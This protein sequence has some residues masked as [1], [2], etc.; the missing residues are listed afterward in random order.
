MSPAADE[1]LQAVRH[2]VER[3]NA[4]GRP[5][6]DQNIAAELGM[7]TAQLHATMRQLFSEGRRVEAEPSG[8]PDGDEQ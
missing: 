8:Q 3:L 2:A 4:A 7:T 1:T 5:A 6:T